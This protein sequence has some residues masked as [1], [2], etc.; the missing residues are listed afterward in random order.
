MKKIKNS[1]KW[2][3]RV[4]ENGSM[5]LASNCPFYFH[6]RKN[7]EG[8]ENFSACPNSSNVNKWPSI[9]IWQDQ[10]LPPPYTQRYCYI[11]ISS[12][13]EKQSFQN[14]WLKAECSCWTY[15][16]N[17]IDIVG[18]VQRWDDGIGFQVQW[19]RHQHSFRQGYVGYYQPGTSEKWQSLHKPK[20]DNNEDMF[21]RKKK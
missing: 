20:D 13:K 14:Q 10:E 2:Q 6:L 4:E 5:K 18:N 3:N 19:A 1:L 7:Y 21:L 12:I 8:A 15:P 17:C 16:E 11:S 9:R